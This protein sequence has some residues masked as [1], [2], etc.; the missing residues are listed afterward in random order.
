M[1]HL[2]CVPDSKGPERAATVRY[3]SR[4]FRGR[5]AFAGFNLHMIG[6]R[7]YPHRMF[8]GLRQHALF[9]VWRMH[10]EKRSAF[11]E[12]GEHDEVTEGKLEDDQGLWYG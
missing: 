10:T 3:S 4:L 8:S 7:G 9:L 2:C 12:K 11:G 1:N 6:G 5:G